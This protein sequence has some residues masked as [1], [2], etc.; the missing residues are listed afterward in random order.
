[1]TPQQ[2]IASVVA[3]FVVIVIGNLLQRREAQFRSGLRKR[4]G[5]G[6]QAAVSKR[7]ER[8]AS[9]VPEASRRRYVAAGL[10]LPSA[11]VGM[12]LAVILATL[13]GVALGTWV[14]IVVDAG[15]LGTGLFAFTGAMLGWGVPETWLRWRINERYAAMIAEFPVMLDLL[16][17]SLEG[18]L[19]LASAWGVVTTHVQGASVALADEMRRV[20]IELQFGGGWRPALASATERTGI[21]DFLLLGSLLEQSERFG[22]ELSRSIRVHADGLRYEDLQTLEERA[23]RSSVKM[24]LPL[25]VMLL[26]ASLLLLAGPLIF[27]LLDTLSGVSAD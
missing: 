25:G 5:G 1:M 11:Q 18:G 9:L 4:L 27:M 24:I 12:F 19:G 6:D 15:V 21:R 14:A 10:D 7:G 26:P 13:L 3:F 8:A 2:I 22:T 16:Q 17:I 20:E 23:H